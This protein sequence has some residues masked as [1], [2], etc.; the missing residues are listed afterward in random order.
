MY[1]VLVRTNWFSTLRTINQSDQL[2]VRENISLTMIK[3]S[4]EME[5]KYDHDFEWFLHI[6]SREINNLSDTDE[7]FIAHY[8]SVSLQLYKESILADKRL[9]RYLLRIKR[10]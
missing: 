9:I 8:N 3:Y 4:A 7:E 2:S 10:L 5:D 6:V 1:R